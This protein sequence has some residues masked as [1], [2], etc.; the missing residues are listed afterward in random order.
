MTTRG[1]FAISPSGA[2]CWIAA[3]VAYGLTLLTG[4]AYLLAVVAVGFTLPLVD[5]GFACAAGGLRLVRPT[6]AV[7]HEQTGVRLERVGTP[8]VEGDLVATLV[9][10][11]GVVTARVC[12]GC[13]ARVLTYVVGPRGP[14][15]PIRWIADSYGPLG[16]AARRRHVIDE[17]PVLAVPRRMP[18]GAA[19]LG[20]DPDGDDRAS[21]LVGVGG[22]PAGI[23]EHRPGDPAR[24][25]HWRST[26]RRGEPIVRE[27]E[28]DAGRQLVVAAGR[29]GPA[30][31]DALARAA[32]TAA[33][34]V[35]DGIPVTLLLGSEVTRPRTPDDVLDAFALLQPGPP[36]PRVP[37]GPLLWLST[38]PPPHAGA[39]LP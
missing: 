1:R 34:A 13:E 29:F 20:G 23:R 35:G 24:H 4:D 8:T 37:D 22:S 15:P 38:T 28:S 19:P 39:V 33:A 30:Q 9:V 7:A 36:P 26:A 32:W 10:P 18:V 16:L 12:A 11:G 3:V 6:R 2:A 5:L 14:V 31:E 21:G 27:W 25:L 17:T